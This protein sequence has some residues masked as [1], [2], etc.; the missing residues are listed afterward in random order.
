MVA[1]QFS[2]ISDSESSSSTL[3]HREFEE[4]PRVFRLPFMF[5]T[6]DTFLRYPVFPALSSELQILHPFLYP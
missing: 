2:V 5:Y 6:G 4:L 1:K 3:L